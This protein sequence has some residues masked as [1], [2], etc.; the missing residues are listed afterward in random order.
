M[1]IKIEFSCCRKGRAHYSEGDVNFIFSEPAVLS[2]FYI[3]KHLPAFHPSSSDFFLH[4][5]FDNN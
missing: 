3:E 5:S 2:L 1:T 4:L